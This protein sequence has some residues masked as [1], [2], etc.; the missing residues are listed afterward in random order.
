MNKYKKIIYILLL[1][2]LSI[3]IIVP[4]ICKIENC[5][6]KVFNYDNNYEINNIFDIYLVFITDIKIILIWFLVQFILGLFMYC[7]YFTINKSKIEN[8]GIKF[9][10]E[11]GTFGSANWMNNQEL[12]DSFEVG[13]EN[14]LI[15]GK[16]Y[17]RLRNKI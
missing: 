6:S 16:L 4:I 2:I 9:K 11:D 10:V 3:L 7:I 12:T 15:V 14:G 8:K 5:L 17:R 1:I 13:T